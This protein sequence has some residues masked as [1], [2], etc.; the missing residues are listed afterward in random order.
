VV[1]LVLVGVVGGAAAFQLHLLKP[2]QE[3]RFTAFTA[4]TSVSSPIGYQLHWSIIAIGSGG[5]TGNGFLAGDQTN[6]GFLLEQQ[7]DFVFTVVGEEG[8]F[9]ACAGVL[10]LLAVVCLRGLR[11]APR[12]A[13]PFSGGVGRESGVLVRLPKLR[14]HRDDRRSDASHWGPA[15]VPVLRR[16][17]DLR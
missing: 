8:G 4:P 7:T 10:A 11:I 16:L 12:A 15:T 13:D 2:Y 9:V 17:G 6:G 1:G 14:Q 3:Q 5:V